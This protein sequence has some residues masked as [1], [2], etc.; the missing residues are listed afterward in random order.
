MRRMLT[1]ALLT[2]GAVVLVAV[3]VFGRSN[4]DELKAPDKAVLPGP[5]ERD[6]APAFTARTVDGRTV[7]LAGYR[8]KPLVINFFAHWCEP[9]KRE[10]P[11]FVQLEQR[12]GD[13]V[14]VLS[15]A[16]ESTMPGV[17]R[18]M[19]TYDMSWP[20]VFDKGNALSDS[21]KVPGQPITYVIDAEGRVVFRIIGETT[22]RRVGGV[23]DDLLRA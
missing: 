19:K 8:G 12:Y 7:S 4:A 18:F 10:A 22:E 20:V 13:R 2:A 23:L 17:K 6:A 11:A 14:A 1:V 3:V 9:C 5:G 21:F 15:I 16:R